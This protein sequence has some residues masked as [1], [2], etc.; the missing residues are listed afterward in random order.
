MRSFREY[1]RGS[2]LRAFHHRVETTSTQVPEQALNKIG[3]WLKQHGY[4][5]KTR[6]DGESLMLAAKKGSSNRLGYIFAHAAIVV[7]AVGGLLD[8]ELPVRLQIL[9]GGKQAITQNMLISEVPEQGRLP[10]A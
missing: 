1:V 5:F 6:Q 3:P 8:S 7:I 9:L 4:R 2:S 10:A